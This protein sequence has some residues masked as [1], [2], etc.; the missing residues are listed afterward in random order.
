MAAKL[1]ITYRKSAIG[2]PQRQKDTIHALGFHKL[3][4]TIERDDTPT[5]RGMIKQVA[6]LVRVEDVGEPAGPPAAAEGSG[7]TG[8]TATGE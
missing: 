1:C 4:N 2:Y 3:N 8:A 5:I 6:H 7:R